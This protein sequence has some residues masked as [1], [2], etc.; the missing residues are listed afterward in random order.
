MRRIA[1]YL[2]VISLLCGCTAIYHSN[3]QNEETLL[4]RMIEKVE[5]EDMELYAV[6]LRG[7]EFQ[8]QTD[9]SLAEVF[10][11]YGESMEFNHPKNQLP[12][13]DY[14]KAVLKEK[15]ILEIFETMS[16]TEL[17]FI[18]MPSEGDAVVKVNL[19]ADKG[20]NNSICFFR[21]GTMMV[22]SGPEYGKREAEF[23]QV[24]DDTINKLINVVYDH[25][26][27]YW[28]KGP[29]VQRRKDDP[30]LDDNWKIKKIVNDSVNN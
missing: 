27:W 3:G 9:G 4:Q 8:K 12:S 22:S 7:I 6:I 26:K 25:F 2:I 13:G 18:Q 20:M 28:T 1:A 19:D 21:N 23:Y 10:C 11:T 30:T 14:M 17:D 16:V 29:G 24:N 15:K 5:T